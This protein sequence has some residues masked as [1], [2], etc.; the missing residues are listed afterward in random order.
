MLVVCLSNLHNAIDGDKSFVTVT[1]RTLLFFF[2]LFFL[3]NGHI[4]FIYFYIYVFI[5][6]IINFQLFEQFSFL[7]KT[8]SLTTH[9]YDGE[10]ARSIAD[11]PMKVVKRFNIARRLVKYFHFNE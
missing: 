4:K 2:L 5:C 7:K 10:V 9:A 8:L 6:A 11:K 1:T 3:L